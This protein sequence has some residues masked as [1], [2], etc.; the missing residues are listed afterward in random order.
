MVRTKTTQIKETLTQ[1]NI[2]VSRKKQSKLKPPQIKSDMC[3]VVKLQL[4][5]IGD[6]K[7]VSIKMRREMRFQTPVSV[8]IKNFYARTGA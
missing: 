8:G 6:R 7:N 2:Y 4:Y 3:E 5:C 1:H